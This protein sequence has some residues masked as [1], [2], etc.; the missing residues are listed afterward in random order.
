MRRKP[1]K[2]KCWNLAATP[3][4]STEGKVRFVPSSEPPR[5][6]QA[7]TPSQVGSATLSSRRPRKPLFTVRTVWPL[8]MQYR[9]AARVAAFMPPA[10]APTLFLDRIFRNHYDKKE[11][12]SLCN[13]DS[14]SLILMHTRRFMGERHNGMKRRQHLLEFGTTKFQSLVEIEFFYSLGYSPSLGRI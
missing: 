10:G 9:T 11:D 13:P 1:S 8:V 2:R 6:I 7:S 3:P 4:R 14:H 5:A 12:C